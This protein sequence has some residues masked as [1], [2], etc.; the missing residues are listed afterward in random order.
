MKVFSA[1][2]V[3]WKCGLAF[4]LAIVMFYVGTKL[5]EQWGR[6]PISNRDS[7]EFETVLGWVLVVFSLQFGVGAA[8]RW[9]NNHDYVRIGPEGIRYLGWSDVTIPWSEIAEVSRR[10]YR[11]Y[12]F[13][14]LRL[15]DR[16]RF[17]RRGW[18]GRISW[19]PEL[20]R[21]DSI[22]ISLNGTDQNFDAAMSAIKFFASDKQVLI[23]D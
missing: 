17:P 7:P 16:Q 2:N 6:P 14:V 4:L 19:L 9:W 5:V 22:D 3:R 20:F 21:C 10:T 15:K 12:R 13:V 18:M 11:R 8:L 23:R 1:N